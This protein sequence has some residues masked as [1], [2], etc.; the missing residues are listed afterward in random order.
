[1]SDPSTFKIPTRVLMLGSGEL[2]KEVVISLQR[3]G[4]HVIAVDSYCGAPAM[5]VA[6]DYRV[7]DMTDGPALAALLESVDVD[8]V[9]PEIEAIATD[10]LL[11][12]EGRGGTRIVPNAFAVKSTMD[13]QAIR[14]LAA[15][16][17]GVA[18][19]KF[20]FASSAEELREAFEHTGLP[21]FI[22][23]TMSSSGHGQSRVCTVDEADE[24]WRVAGEGARSHTGRVIVEEEIRFD[25]EITLLTIRS[26]DEDLNTAVTSFCAPIGHRQVDGDYVESWQPAAISPRALERC[27]EMALLVTDALADGGASPALGIFGV[28]FFIR[29]DDAWFSELSPRPHDT[30][31]VTMVTQHQSEFELH[32]RAILGLPIDPALSSPGASAVITSTGVC[33][34]PRY[35]GV[36]RALRVADDV[37]IFGKPVTRAGR[38][39]GVVLA[40]GAVADEARERASAGAACVTIRDVQSVCG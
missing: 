29:G 6:D 20:R 8:L 36:G 7:I 10:E 14:A 17:D 11:R 13:R 35:E 28:E 4:C 40:R 1:M 33:A 5:Q 22:K 25:C 2:G 30:G 18:T 39:L 37:R 16:L 21:A 19:S 3:L 23:P 38:R 27:Q 24:A 34:D 12:F 31:M 32:A 9:V 15:G 26:W